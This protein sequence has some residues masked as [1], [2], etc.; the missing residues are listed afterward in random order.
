M[1]RYFKHV[2]I[3]LI[4]DAEKLNGDEKRAKGEGDEGVDE[5]PIETDATDAAAA[6]PTQEY[7]FGERVDGLFAH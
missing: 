4:A 5:A 3:Q 7:E 2:P 6:H 1:A